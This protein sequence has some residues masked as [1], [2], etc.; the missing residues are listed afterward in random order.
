M[1]LDVFTDLNKVRN[2]GIMAHI[3]AGKTTTTERILFYTGI[4][5]KIGETHDGASTMDWMAQEQERG[6][7]ITSAAT[8]CFWKDNQINIIDTP[9]HVDFTVEVERSLRV[10]DG[11]VA[12]FDGKEGVEPQS[13]TVWRQADK[14]DVPRICFVN[15]MDKMG[16]DFYFTV[17]TIIDRLGAR[18]LV[19][20]LPIGAES[21]FLGVVDLLEM[22]AYVWPG[23]AKGDVTMGASY[24][25]QDIPA[26]LVEK[27]EQYRAELVEA[28][29]EASE[30][31]M[32][33]Y[34]EEGELSIPEIKAGIR[35]LV[36]AG[37]AFPVLCGSAFKNR[38]VQ[39]M[40]DAVIEYLPSPL[41]V[42]D[43]VGSNPSNEEEKLTRKAS[44]DEPFAA[45]AF[46]VAAHP[47]YG[48]LTYTRVYS[49]VAAQGQ[50][51]LNS[52]KGKKERIGKLFQM[53]SN[54][55]NPVEEIT[56]GHIYA[57]IGLK[58]TTTGDTL[59]DPA[60][61]IVLE[62][63][64]FPDPVI[65]VAIEPKT[66]GDQEK[67]STAIQKL[68][69]EDPTFTVSLNEETGQTEIGGMGELHLDIIVDRMKREF[70]VEANV[71]KPQVAYRE[72][73]K[74]AVEKVDYTHK[75]QTGGSGQ[76]AKVQVSF[77]PLPL[78]GEELYLFEDKVTGGRVPREYIPSV[79]A[80]IQDAMKFGVLAGYPMVGVKATLIDGA[81]HDVDSSEMAFKIAGSMV[82]KEGAKRANPV[83]LEPLMDVEVRT[84]EEYMGDV[85]GDLN[86]RR[87]QV[88]SMED[89]SGV[90]I[91]KAIVPLTEMFGY[92]GD[93][94]GKTQGRAVFSMAFD[95][96]GEVPKNVADEIIQKSRGE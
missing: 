65:F 84:P 5:H 40:L 81:Y 32:E 7:T 21:D 16:A 92:I 35:Q 78:D 23:D 13:E 72:T 88:R 20:Q 46:K 33:K 58:D 74:K 6:I 69:A 61:P 37:E 12:V 80:G 11:A 89:A 68:S 54:K 86:S 2:I 43:V 15:K 90:K 36:I 87:G 62:S 53:H 95:S 96:Y 71:G 77:E 76:F 91:I 47:F 10:L 28:V 34:L 27:A 38:G 22:K 55:E 66:K 82:F 50:Q 73:I 41:D 49:G 45:L 70:K 57:A 67:M 18:P 1:A 19:V 51:V 29:A 59:C 63:M 75:K 30:E 83:L 14:Y 85:I 9:G 42:P 52:T 39:P 3:D 25:V 48:Q 60:H 56:A 24:E 8:T 31:L 64:T 4:N 17:Q 94:R 44:A 26:D 79:D 93:L